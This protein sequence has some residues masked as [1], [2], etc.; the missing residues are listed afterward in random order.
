V[1]LEPEKSIEKPLVLITGEESALRKLALERLLEA[2]QVLPDDFDLQT[3]DGDTHPNDW[4]AA[5]GTA[6]FLAERRVVIVRHVLRCDLDRAKGVSFKLPA[7]ALLVLVADDE[8]G[9]DD[10]QRRLKTYR[11]GWEKLVKEAGGNQIT[12]TVDSGAIKDLVRA[13]LAKSDKRITDRGLDILSEMCAGSASRALEEV[14]K[15]VAYVEPEKTVQE[16]DVNEVVVPAREWNVFKLVDSVVE[17]DV[18]ESLRQLRILVGSPQKAEDAAFRNILPQLSRSLRLLWQARVCIDAGA[19]PGNPPEAVRV[20][21]LSKP[22]LATEKD[23]VRNKAMRT[24]RR[25]SL[26][27]ISAMLTLLSNADS[28]L[29][30]QLPS[31]SAMETLEQTVLKM[32]EV[33]RPKLATAR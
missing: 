17:G 8:S 3:F 10:R 30:G 27:Q 28:M 2:A 29:K 6:P 22:N 15:L 9:D 14:P 25:V 7:S 21:L 32:A 26:E 18:G 23:F 12:C 20:A 33:A 24:A 1:K 11:T 5:A 31:F 16:S 13:E 4:L 19:Q